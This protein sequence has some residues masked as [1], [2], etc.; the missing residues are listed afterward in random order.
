MED[1]NKIPPSKRNKTKTSQQRQQQQKTQL[2]R[3]SYHWKTLE[4][5][6]NARHANKQTHIR[7]D[8]AKQQKSEPDRRRLNRKKRQRQTRKKNSQNTPKISTSPKNINDG[9]RNREEDSWN[10]HSPRSKNNWVGFGSESN[11][12]QIRISWVYV[13]CIQNRP[14]NRHPFHYYSVHSIHLFE[15]CVCVCFIVSGYAA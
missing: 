11:T 4:L 6:Q 5:K 1:S 10:Q 9:E 13:V 7:S 12:F 3:F 2:T 8:S 14:L 15:L